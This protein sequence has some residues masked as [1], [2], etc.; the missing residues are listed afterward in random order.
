MARAVPAK[1]FTTVP[2]VVSPVETIE[3]HVAAAAL[4]SLL[5]QLPQ[6]PTYRLASAE[7]VR[8]RLLPETL[9]SRYNPL[10]HD[11][12]V[13]DALISPDAASDAASP[14]AFVRRSVTRSPGR[15]SV[16]R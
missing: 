2:A 8:L 4:G 10:T 15:P 5:I 1:Y 14:A 6:T 7:T 12:V 13:A 16:L 3:G 11:F 9:K